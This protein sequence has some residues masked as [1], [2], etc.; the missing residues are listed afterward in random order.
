VKNA[1]QKLIFA[2]CVDVKALQIDRYFIPAFVLVALNTS[3]KNG[4]FFNQRKYL[5]ILKNEFSL[6]KKV[7]FNG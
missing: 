4:L 1:I 3:T 5:N 7:W 2:E 6:K